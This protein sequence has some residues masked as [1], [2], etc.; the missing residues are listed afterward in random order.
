MKRRLVRLLVLAVAAAGTEID[1]PEKKNMVFI[2]TRKC[3]SSTSGGVA[4]RMAAHRNLSHAFDGNK[5]KPD[6]AFDDMTEPLVFAD[7]IMRQDLEEHKDYQ[8]LQL[9]RFTWT[10]IRHPADRALSEFYHLGVVNGGLEPTDEKIIEY[11]NKS[12]NF[13][14]HYVRPSHCQE[15][16]EDVDCVLDAYDFIGAV[17]LYDQSMVQLAN[18]AQLP[19]RAVLYTPAKIS[20]DRGNESGAMNTGLDGQSDAVQTFLRSPGWI[21]K[22]RVDIMLWQEV[23]RRIATRAN[24]EF[25]VEQLNVFKAMLSSVQKYCTDHRHLNHHRDCYF[26]DAGCGYRC[27]D[28]LFG[29]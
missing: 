28:D 2:K 24:E 26:R 16:V 6:P 11:V 25:H 19:L 8:G 18:A 29:N 17:E 1:P 20:A 23:V 4:R 14:F 9:P 13:V 27:I 21:Y 7:H 22:N 10:M 15:T 12:K 5:Y 3:A